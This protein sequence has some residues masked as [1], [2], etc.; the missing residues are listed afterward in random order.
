MMGNWEFGAGDL[1]LETVT[2]GEYFEV[3]Y[4]VG[5]CHGDESNA[6]QLHAVSDTSGVIYASVDVISQLNA[7]V[8]HH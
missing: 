6:R 5:C 2:N 8:A 3:L 1:A 4:T 7:R